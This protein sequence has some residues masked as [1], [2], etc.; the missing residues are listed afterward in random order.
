VSHID[1]VLLA[2]AA[3]VYPTLL[4]GVI[5]ILSR[6]D[7]LRM[8]I[9]F[10][11]GGMAIS[12]VTGYAIVKAVESSG[13]MSMSSSSTK[14]IVDITVGA[15]SLLIAWGIWSGHIKRH[16]TGDP[17]PDPTATNKQRSSLTSRALSRGSVTMAFIAGLVLNLPGVWYLDALV[18]IAK[19]NSSNASAL[20]Q[21]LVFNLIMFAVVEI[22]V[23]AY[24]VDPGRTG[25][26][27]NEL[28][29]WS[30]THSRTIA[31]VVATIIGLWL[32]TKG[33]TDLTKS[34][35]PP[36]TNCPRR[37]TSPRWSSP[38]RSELTWRVGDAPNFSPC[39]WLV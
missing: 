26:L 38:P 21:I 15:V 2:L 7:P 23:F 30:H 5:L 35:R 1:L 36:P 16:R 32:L 24:L 34:P 27:V 20:A 3:A 29:G 31:I 12:V 39:S 25:E 14:P 28:S 6:P 13:I 9:A 17:Q 18:G 10:L 11:V 19:A 37:S 4:A 33:I 8:L 22:P